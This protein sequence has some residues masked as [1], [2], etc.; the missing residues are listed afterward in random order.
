[1]WLCGGCYFHTVKRAT[2]ETPPV[3]TGAFSE[4]AQ[5]EELAGLVASPEASCWIS[6]KPVKSVNS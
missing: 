6:H 3:L 2:S 4:E 5:I 1:M